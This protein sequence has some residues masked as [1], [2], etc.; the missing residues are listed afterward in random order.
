MYGKSGAG[1]CAL[2]LAFED[3]DDS[4]A[5]S[6]SG[7]TASDSAHVGGGGSGSGRAHAVTD[8]MSA[9]CAEMLESART[10]ELG[11]LM[12]RSMLGGHSGVGLGVSPE[13]R[14]LLGIAYVDS[15]GDL[16]PARES[17]IASHGALGWVRRKGIGY[18]S[19]VAVLPGA[20]GR[21]IARQL[22]ETS[23]ALASSWGCRSVGLHCNASNGPA[24][25]LYNKMGYRRTVLEP[26]I[27][28]WLNGRPP[29]RCHF[30]LRRLPRGDGAAAGEGDDEGDAPAAEWG[31][32]QQ[33]ALGRAAA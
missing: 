4:G 3:D 30:F 28:P 10:S 11:S 17:N 19:N 23:E 12:L 20:R 5:P 29:T 27:M 24:V 18:I 1:S 15:F 33:P 6:S 26:A 13:Q 32:G 9:A 31:G 14:R 7:R 16:V 2:L 25:S 8:E 21:G 22:V